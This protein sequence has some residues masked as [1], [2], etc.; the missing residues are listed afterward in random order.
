MGHRR[1]SRFSR[2]K[3]IRVYCR[4]RQGRGCSAC[5]TKGYKPS[6]DILASNVYING[7]SLDYTESSTSLPTTLTLPGN[8]AVVFQFKV[9]PL[10]FPYPVATFGGVQGQIR[11]PIISDPLSGTI[12]GQPRLTAP[13]SRASS[14]SRPIVC[15]NSRRNSFADRIANAGFY[16]G[17]EFS[18]SGRGPPTVLGTFRTGEATL[19]SWDVAV[20]KA[21]TAVAYSN[22]GNRLAMST[23]TVG[24][25]AK[26]IILRVSTQTGLVLFWTTGN[27]SG[28]LGTAPNV[29][30]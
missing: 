2:G 28:L 9:R 25:L 12:N 11:Q 1:R 19:F 20:Q 24:F 23:R 14:T 30:R 26:A 16:F 15:A 7:I 10:P 6:P 13:K 17:R 4:L 8:A 5:R 29:T 27:R 22:N 21:R 18:E 3:S